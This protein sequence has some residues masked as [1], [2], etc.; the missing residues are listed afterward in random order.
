V[1]HMRLR[2]DENECY[3]KYDAQ[4]SIDRSEPG[5]PHRIGPFPAHLDE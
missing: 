1:L 5:L 4:F 2:S 3:E